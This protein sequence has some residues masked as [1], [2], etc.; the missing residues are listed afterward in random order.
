[1]GSNES[2]LKI[3]QIIQNTARCT[4]KRVDKR[5]SVSGM[6]AALNLLT[7]TDRR[8]LH[9]QTECYKNVTTPEASLS[10]FFVL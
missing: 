9:F 3:L 10:K 4:V 7:L 2:D 1:M 5:T 6:H 8:S